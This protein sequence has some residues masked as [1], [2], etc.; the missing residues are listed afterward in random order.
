MSNNNGNPC[1]APNTAGGACVELPMKP[2]YCG[3][4]KQV[5]DDPASGCAYYQKQCNSNGDNCR[6]SKCLQ[7]INTN[8]SSGNYSEAQKA[9][10]QTYNG[11]CPP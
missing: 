9:A 4:L 8:C 5:A 2:G 1:H 3:V 7:Y 6:N 11:C 10:Q